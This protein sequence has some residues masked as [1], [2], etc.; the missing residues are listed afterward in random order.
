MR[1]PI[2]ILAGA[3]SLMAAGALAHPSVV[4]PP[5]SF[6]S[7]LPGPEGL[8][9]GKDGSLYVGTADGDVHRVAADGSHT[10][11]ASTGD[12]LAGITVAQDG[13]IFA[14]GFNQNR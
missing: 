3:L 2:V 8:A 1:I 6:A 14:C 9:F 12:R 11:V 10:V 13:K 5:T 4:Q 7:G